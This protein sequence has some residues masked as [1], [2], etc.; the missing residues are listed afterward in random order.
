MKI[1]KINQEKAGVVSLEQSDAI[2]SII[3]KYIRQLFRIT[4]HNHDV[5]RKQSFNEPSVKNSTTGNLKNS[6]SGENFIT[7]L[8]NCCTVLQ[9]FLK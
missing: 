5:K 9:A 8:Y 1:N 2:S 7:N 3:H 6:D 4:S